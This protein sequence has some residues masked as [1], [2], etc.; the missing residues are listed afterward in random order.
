MNATRPLTMTGSFSAKEPIPVA[1]RM[2]EGFNT[3]S[4]LRVDFVSE[5]KAVKLEDLVGQTVNVTLH[6][7]QGPNREFCGTIITAEALGTH[8][9]H[10]L[11]S[12]E[13]R[14]W[15]WFLTRT[16]ECRI[17]QDMSAL[18][19]IKEIL[20]DY[21]FSSK[22]T[23]KTTDTFPPRVICVQYRETDL[24]FVHRLMEEE[25]IYYFFDHASGEEKMILADSASAHK[26]IPGSSTLEYKD[27]GTNIQSDHIYA[28]NE[29]ERVVSGK[30]TLTDFDF[31]KPKADLTA[32][33][34]LPKGKHSYKDKEV[35]DY[36]GHY[37][38]NADG[39]RYS[40][41]KMESH[42]APHR[43]WI[44][45][46]NVGTLSCGGTFKLDRH[47]RTGRGDEFI[48]TRCL[49]EVI[50]APQF[51]PTAGSAIAQGRRL[52]RVDGGK[53]DSVQV[54]IETLP[55]DVQ[56]RAQQVTPWPAI[57]GVHTAIVT[58]PKGE[59]IHTDKYGRI[60]IQ[61]HW[62]RLGKKDDTST[63]WVRHMTPWSGKNWGMIHIP[64]IGQ[65]VVV[66]FEEGDPDRPLVIGM[67]YNADTMPPYGLDANKTQSGIK[68]NSSKG[69][70][71]FNELMFE[72][73]KDE[74][75][76]RFQSEKDY[77]Q[78]VKNDA[79]IT[80]GLEKKDPGS[81]DVTIHKDLTETIKTGDHTFT[82][83]KGDQTMAVTEGKQTETIKGNVA[84]TVQQGNVTNS[85]K[86]GNIATT[87]DMGNQKTNAKMGS[88]SEQAMQK[89]EMKVGG[90]SITID[91][92]GITIKGI[93]V[94]IEGSA[95]FE[96]K[97]PMSTVKGD[98]LLI[99]KGGLTMIN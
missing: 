25:G 33:K 88:I 42:A 58:G 59:E 53:D 94:K 68:T 75:L 50:V 23:D 72:D 38:E 79:T 31:E 18:D 78:I 34:P 44:G 7:T 46:G 56:Y 35:Y 36:P 61:F 48:I 47:D 60:R 99:L 62:D 1:L 52:T 82:V 74:E 37:R 51:D 80:V 19:I 43:T 65:E 6:R 14:P 40:K 91:Q 26:A 89:I 87:L 20:G 45:T 49:H 69:G 77:E 39:D 57:S 17:Y 27:A 28:W 4:D 11:Y 3:L 95:M 84:F 55:K 73:K 22:L 10:A 67:L 30:V 64:R 63:C 76:V 81:M 8:S 13:A 2:A 12:I 70:G 85:I 93:M 86:Q 66:Q 54:E 92:T 98:G 90:N 41:I 96:A 21:G 24:D 97:S 32:Q 5:D 16:Q 71:G 15:L 29:G 83:E 9:G